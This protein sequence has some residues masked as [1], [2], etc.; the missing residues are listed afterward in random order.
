M[1]KRRRGGG[2]Q[3][4]QIGKFPRRAQFRRARGV[5]QF[6]RRTRRNVR[7]GG[8]LG[9]ETKFYD[10]F[11]LDRNLTKPTDGSGGECDQSATVGPTTIAQGDGES[12]RDGRKCVV[13]SCYVTGII[14]VP[15]QADQIASDIGGTV[16]VA[17]VQDTQTNGA[18]L[19]SED[20]FTNPGGLDHLATSP[21]RN[22]QYTNRFKVLARKLIQLPQAELVY[23]G[24]NIEQGGFH[25]PFML[26][27][28]GV[29]P[30]L[31]TGTTSD[32]S[33]SVTN[34]LHIVAYCSDTTQAPAMSYNCRVRFVG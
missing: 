19:N 27:W 29:M 8:F 33:N 7:T 21:L 28:R 2:V 15:K 16:F 12:N 6:R 26:S 13:K 24:T 23:D 11:L 25:V 4:A 32:I 20:V 30:M 9:I 3:R 34:S 22:M 18:L 10:T 14:E 1:S 17:L 5:H 31:F